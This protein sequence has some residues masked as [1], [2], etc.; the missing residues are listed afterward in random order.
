VRLF[1]L[2]C[3]VL[4]ISRLQ[5]AQILLLNI[6]EWWWI[7]KQEVTIKNTG[8]HIPRMG[9]KIRK[10]QLFSAHGETRTCWEWDDTRNN[11]RSPIS[12]L[13]LLVQIAQSNGKTNT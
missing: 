12:L 1:I 10:K 7:T 13:P 3:V 11:Y 6:W 9:S 8:N 5:Q 2:F 4:F